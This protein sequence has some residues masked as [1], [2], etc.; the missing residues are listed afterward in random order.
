MA[1]GFGPE[2]DALRP[3]E[4]EDW[5]PRVLKPIRPTAGNTVGRVAPAELIDEAP[6]P[7]PLVRDDQILDVEA[8]LAIFGM[9][10]DLQEVGAVRAQD[11]LDVRGHLAEPGWVIR[12]RDGLKP[13]CFIV[14]AL[15]CV[16]RR[17]DDH[18]GLRAGH[19]GRKNRC[20]PAVAADE[21]VLPDQPEIACAGDRLNG[22]FAGFFFVR[23]VDRFLVD[24][25][26]RRDRLLQNRISLA[27]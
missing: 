1:D 2:L 3:G 8:A 16:G 5:L 13:D 25:V 24:L 27:C 12:W 23:F 20:V 4:M 26:N 11:R 22:R 21:P 19:K 14:R 7:L 6:A 17:G 10:F 18:V 9:L 15:G